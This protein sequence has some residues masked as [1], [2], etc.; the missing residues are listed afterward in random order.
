MT[1][2]EKIRNI[3]TVNS[4]TQKIKPGVMSRLMPYLQNLR[5][6]GLPDNLK[7]CAFKKERTLEVYTEID[8]YLHLLKSY[9]FTASSGEL[10][11][12]L[13]EGDQQI[14]EGI[15]KIDYLNPNSLFYLSMKI[16]Y[17]NAFD[18]EKSKLDNR[19]NIGSDIFIHG[20]NQTIGC[21]PI[22]DKAIE[23]LFL[24]V[25]HAKNLGK[26]I[27]IIIAPLD[28]RKTQEYPKINSVNW[29]K[30]LYGN[31]KKSL[32]NYNYRS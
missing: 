19:D 13:K 25:S 17:P 15:Y 30:E 23:E 20:S 26:E 32:G 21:I 9:K 29:E 11:P 31:I 14:P 7:L 6:D 18:I 12:K 1:S 10:G 5:L 3:E 16:N 27:E 22:G 28:F 4:I 24:L 8:G 2:K